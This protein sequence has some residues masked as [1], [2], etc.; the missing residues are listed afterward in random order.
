MY[1]VYIFGYKYNHIDIVMMCIEMHVSIS[2]NWN[3]NEH[4]K[5]SKSSSMPW[6]QPDLGAVARLLWHLRR[7]VTLQ[8]PANHQRAMETMGQLGVSQAL[9]Y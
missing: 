9:N 8:A 7:C 6:H 1:N 4:E 2:A 3:V 5:S